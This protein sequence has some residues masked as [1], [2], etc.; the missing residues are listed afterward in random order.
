MVDIGKMTYTIK[1][2]N[3]INQSGFELKQWSNTVKFTDVAR[4]RSKLKAD[5]GTYLENDDFQI[6]YIMPGHGAKG[7]QVPI[8]YLEDLTGMYGRCSRTKHI[9]LWVKPS[10]KKEPTSG[11][12]DSRVRKR[13]SSDASTSLQQESAGPSKRSK[14]GSDVGNSRLKYGAEYNKMFE[15]QEIV[16]ELEKRHGTQYTIEQLRAWGNMMIMKKHDSLDC[17]P[18]KPF[19]KGKKTVQSTNSPGKRIKYRSECMDQL[20]KWHSL[21]SRG[22]ST[23]EQYDE[24]QESILSDIKRLNN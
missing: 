3:V 9:V 12:S 15:L 19:F 24:F 6:G 2:I 17:P 21:L 14:P 16:D 20:D 23:Q 11:A 7:K 1:F 5:F 10:R 4:L 13:T 22:V 8:T 18:D